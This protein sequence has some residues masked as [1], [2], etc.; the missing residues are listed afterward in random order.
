MALKSLT[1]KKKIALAV[2]LSTIVVLS[3]GIG[4]F[5]YNNHIFRGTVTYVS[6]FSG[7]YG[8]EDNDENLYQPIDLPKEFQIEGLSVFVIARKCPDRGSFYQWGEIVEI[9]FIKTL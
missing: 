9:R 7:Y 6:S 3:T 8:I 1:R 5:F 4:I 2:L